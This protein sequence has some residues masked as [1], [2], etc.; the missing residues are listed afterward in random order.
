MLMVYN[1]ERLLEKVLL[2]AL[3]QTKL[4]IPHPKLPWLLARACSQN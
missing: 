2:T 3:L 4:Y 1:K